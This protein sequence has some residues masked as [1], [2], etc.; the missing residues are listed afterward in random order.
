MPLVL[1]AEAPPAP[2]FGLWLRLGDAMARNGLRTEPARSFTPHM[3]LLYD[4]RHIE[5]YAV[6]PVTWRARVRAVHSRH[7]E[8]RHIWLGAGRCGDHGGLKFGFAAARAAVDTSRGLRGH[9]RSIRR[10][11][12]SRA[13]IA[14]RQEGVVNRNFIYV[15]AGLV[16]GVALGTAS[17]YSFPDKA[18]AADVAKYM[19]L[20]APSSSS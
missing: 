10:R 13:P 7:G 20:S 19:S 14:N 2:L 4:V 9:L 11:S 6:E 15:M 1:R 5:T 16:L 18:T 17:Y 12:S 8:T 3:T